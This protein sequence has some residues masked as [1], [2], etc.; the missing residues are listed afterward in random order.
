MFSREII[1]NAHDQGTQRLVQ[2]KGFNISTF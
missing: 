2:I 1:V